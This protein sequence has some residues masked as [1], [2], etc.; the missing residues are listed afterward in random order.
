MRHHV[1]PVHILLPPVQDQFGRILITF[2]VEIASRA[3]P[4]AVTTIN[5]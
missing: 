2:G 4:V 1:N 3:E 5:Q